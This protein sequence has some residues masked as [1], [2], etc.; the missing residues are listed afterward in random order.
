[1]ELCAS[2]PILHT[3]QTLLTEIRRHIPAPRFDFVSKKIAPY[4]HAYATNTDGSTRH[5]TFFDENTFTRI[6]NTAIRARK[7][8]PTDLEKAQ[9]DF[10]ALVRNIE[11]PNMETVYTLID[12]AKASCLNETTAYMWLLGHLENAPFEFIETDSTRC[13]VLNNSNF[14]KAVAYLKEYGPKTRY[15][16]TKV[17]AETVQKIEPSEVRYVTLD[18]VYKALASKFGMDKAQTRSCVNGLRDFVPMCKIQR[19]K[20]FEGVFPREVADDLVKTIDESYD[21]RDFVKRTINLY[22]HPKTQLLY[23][24]TDLAKAVNFDL[25][26]H[27]YAPLHTFIMSLGIGGR[28][29]RDRGSL[30]FTEE[31]RSIFIEAYN[32]KYGK[33]KATEPITEPKT[34]NSVVRISINGLDLN[35]NKAEALKIAQSI[36]NQIGG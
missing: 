14:F 18:V 3:A 23:T 16:T 33:D 30:L 13:R 24:A 25:A 8:N 12:V 35:L 36:M 29:D 6:V 22:D 34:S 28:F 7:A 1:M 27:D 17:P 15:N 31:D 26:G 21:S 9:E 11:K 5:Y 20:F 2:Q 10:I 32:S 4:V 19:G